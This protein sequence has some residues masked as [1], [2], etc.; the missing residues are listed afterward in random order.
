M[1][2]GN[3]GEV[4]NVAK[5]IHRESVTDTTREKPVTKQMLKEIWHWDGSHLD[6]VCE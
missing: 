6:E 2:T 3:I 1:K 4:E 5:R